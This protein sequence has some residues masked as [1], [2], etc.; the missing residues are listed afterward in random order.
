MQAYPQQFAA[1]IIARL[2][3]DVARLHNRIQY[4]EPAAVLNWLD[5]MDTELETYM[6]RMSA[7]TEAALDGMSFDRICTSLRDRG[8]T[9]NRAES[10]VINEDKSPLAWLLVAAK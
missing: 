1:G 4:H 5:C 7:M 3:S 8:C 6:D 9:L 10:L 2:Y